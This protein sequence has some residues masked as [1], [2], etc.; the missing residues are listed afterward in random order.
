MRTADREIISG[1]KG[2]WKE[3]GYE[4]FA[5]GTFGNGGQNLYVSRNGELQRIFRF[6]ITNSGYTDLLFANSHDFGER[7]PVYVIE[8]ALSSEKAHIKELRTEG[9]HAG[10]IGDLNDDGYDDI[11]IAGQNNGLHQDLMAFVYYGSPE[12]LSERYKYELPAPDCRDVAI[13]D[14]N[15]DGLK[16]I[17]FILGEDKIRIFYQ[18]PQGF[19]PTEY[20][21]LAVKLTHLAAG[22]LDGDGCDELYVRVKENKPRILWGGCDGISL[23]KYTEFGE[24]INEDSLQ[25]PGAGNLAP[26]LQGRIPKIITWRGKT[27]LFYANQEKTHLIAANP[28]RTLETRL[29]LD[30]GP[31]LSVA[32]GDISGKGKEDLILVSRQ[33]V[34]DHEVSWIYWDNNGYS[35]SNRIGIRTAN[36]RDAAI[37]DING[38]GFAE[39]VICQG[40]APLHLSTESLI[41]CV[42]DSGVVKDPIKFKTHDAVDV[43]VGR[44]SDSINPQVIF[45]NHSMSKSLGQQN[46]YAYLGSNKGYSP[47]RRIELPGHSACE[48]ISCD[49]NQDGWPDLLV[50]NNGEDQPKLNPPSYLYWGGPDGFK[51]ERRQEISTNLSWGATVGDVDRDGNLEIIAGGTND[52]TLRIFR[53][54][55]GVFDINYETIVIDMKPNEIRC[56]LWPIMA[57]FNNDGWLDLF[58]PLIS[59]SKS[60]ILWGGPEGFSM[61]RST[62]LPVE[63]ARSARAADLTGNGYLD[64]V[65]GTYPSGSRLVEHDCSIM[66]YWGGPEGYSTSRCSMLPGYQT[67]SMAIADFNHDGNLDIFVGSYLNSRERDLDS[68]IYWGQPGGFYS[69]MHRSR[70]FGHSIS[71]CFAADI[72]EDGYIDLVCANHRAYGNHV[73]ESVVWWNGPAGFSEQKRTWLPT[74][75]PHGMCSVEPANIMSRGNEEYY[76]SNPQFLA[77]GNLNIKISWEGVI[78]IKTWVKA[79]M[80]F[81]QSAELLEKAQWLGINGPDSWLNNC[82]SIKKAKKFGPWVQYRLALGAVNCGNTPRISEVMIEYSDAELSIALLE[83]EAFK[84]YI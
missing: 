38:N 20:T 66:I 56:V 58:L 11:V 44:T 4:A 16:D 10:A 59:S 7:P 79:K 6:D 82:E 28:D 1:T 35:N 76:T 71:G 43:L 80:R 31:V 52:N 29:V 15:G 63:K 33:I 2:S 26:V 14:F 72:D 23:E 47:E 74:I 21:D 39:I 57:D 8:N 18:T 27:H 9:A 34:D 60:L 53:M 78:P 46:V 48:I 42:S 41:Y 64:L 67:N 5:D 50:V 30:T 51:P 68:Y 24:F 40:R 54:R 13:G 65:I 17:A 32:V 83:P 55:N 45:V 49:F 25:I 77:D 36:A 22:D 75:G 37:A 19:L 84:H 73:A 3:K 12:G 70:L 81:A 69:P 62:F 61:K